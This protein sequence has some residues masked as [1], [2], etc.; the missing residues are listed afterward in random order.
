[1]ADTLRLDYVISWAIDRGASVRLIGDDQ[2]LGAIAAGGILRD[3]AAAHGAVRLDEVVRFT[4]P[5]EAHASLA[6]RDGDPAAL[7]FYL[8]HDRIHVGDADTA[9]QQVFNA[10]LTDKRAGLDAIM[11]APTRDKVAQLNQQARDHRLQGHRPEREAA[12]SDGNHASIG[13]TVTTRRNDRNLRAG[14]GW[15][16]NGDRWQVLDVRTRRR[17]RR[18]R[19]TDPPQAHPPRQLRQ[20]PR[21][22]RL[23]LHHPRRPGHDS[24]HLPRPA[25]RTRIPPAAVHDA[26]PRPAREPRLP[27]GHRRRRPALPIPA[28]LDRPTHTDRTPRSDPRPLRHTRLGH[29]P[30]RRAARPTDAAR[31]RCRPISG[32]HHRRRRT[33]RR[34][35]PDLTARRGRRGTP[36]RSHRGR[37]LAGRE[38]TPAG[39]QRRR[40]RPHRRPSARDRR[41]RP[42]G[43]PRPRRRHRPPPRHHQRSH[44][45]PAGATALAPPRA[46]GPCR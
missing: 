42:A 44:C 10:W 34:T 8:D 41:R 27:P 21:R 16:K 20:R 28:G 46:R 30:D 25:H 32:R 13:D 14:A 19:P 33:A 38:I 29:H 15:V 9:A 4:D 18:H 7:G 12:L 1:M 40:H 2:Q 35:P 37:R 39:A 11:L 31:R 6:L 36:A 5:A 23:R 26:Q 45:D 43:R 17:P 3:I 24:R 22:T